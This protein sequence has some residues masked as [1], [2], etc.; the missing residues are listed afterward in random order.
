MLSTIRATAERLSRRSATSERGTM[1][2]MFPAA[3][4]VM[5]VLA[6]MV[7]DVGYTTV[8]GRELQAVANSAAN[9][10]LG[11]IDVTVLRNTGHVVMNKWTARD[12]I[13]EAIALGPLPNAHIVDIDIARYEIA[14]TL[15]IRFDLV[16]APALGD[17]NEV[18]LTRTGRASIIK[19]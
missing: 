15:R 2:L 3:L 8:R 17:L 4:M 5:V 14:I 12:I 18:I 11:A 1:L 19:E 6:A 9:D 13:L 10:A 7:V 16:M